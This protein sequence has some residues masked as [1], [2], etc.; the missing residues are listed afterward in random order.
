MVSAA[1]R[2]AMKPKIQ[3]IL[4]LLALTTSAPAQTRDD[5][6][7]FA[8][9]NTTVHFTLDTSFHTVH[10]SFD[11][12]RGAVHFSPSTGAISGEIVIDATTGQSGND[13]RDRKMHKDVLDSAHYPDIVFRPDRV[14]GNVA[15]QGPSTIQVHGTFSLHGADHE[16]TVPV[17][18]EM[19]P[20]SWTVTCHFSVP[21][22]KWGLKNPSTFI[23]RAN[24]AVALD[25]HAS[26]PK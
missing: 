7:E 1:I 21:Y 19:A 12:K 22:V 10:G 9:A 26:S 23:L 2:D 16:M 5:V 24:E 6:L 11:L 13:G 25:I 4:L 15:P 14:E 8:P 3:F 20:N 18:V 17:Q